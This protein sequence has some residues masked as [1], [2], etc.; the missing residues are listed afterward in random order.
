MKYSSSKVTAAAHVVHNNYSEV[1]MFDAST[2]ELAWAEGTVRA[3][4]ERLGDSDELVDTRKRNTE[5]RIQNL[6]L[7]KGLSLAWVAAGGSS[8]EG[9]G[10]TP[11]QVSWRVQDA[12]AEAKMPVDEIVVTDSMVNALALEFWGASVVYDREK[13]R[14][15]LA[16]ALQT[17]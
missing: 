1:D 7:S 10:I 4:I 9:F 6:E 11:Q 14:Q 16:F 8:A 12:I 15:A 17:R 5:L 2:G 3:A 13:L